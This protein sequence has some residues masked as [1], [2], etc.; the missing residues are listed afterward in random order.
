MRVRERTARM[1]SA[2]DADVARPMADARSGSTAIGSWAGRWVTLMGGVIL[3]VFPPLG[4]ASP[5]VAAEIFVP[6]IVKG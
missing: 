2:A 4:A 1:A 5:R 3:G 6:G